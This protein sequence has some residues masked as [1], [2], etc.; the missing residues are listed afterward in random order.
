[1]PK[2]NQKKKMALLGLLP[3]IAGIGWAANHWLHRN[4]SVP[5]ERALVP[6]SQVPQVAVTGGPSP[7]AARVR[8]EQGSQDNRIDTNLEEHVPAW[9]YD[10]V[11]KEHERPPQREPASP[12]E[13]TP[14]GHALT[15][16]HS[17]E[18]ISILALLIPFVAL[19]IAIAVLAAYRT[20]VQSSAVVPG[21]D[22]Q[23]GRALLQSWGCGSC[24]TIPGVDGADGKVGPNLSEVGLHSFIAGHLQNT[25]DN[26]VEWIMHPQQIAPG[27]GMPDT[28]V[29][30]SIARNMAAY[31][32]SLNSNQRSSSLNFNRR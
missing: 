18:G 16:D 5:R 29:P 28:N 19:A 1:M 31:L 10:K 23:Q 9:V 17:A 24:H 14:A 20:P 32:Y 30:E 2:R 7:E 26:M 11:Q 3:V 21:G 15:G 12:G 25:P 8:E 4:K 6:A 22:A 27:N 13:E